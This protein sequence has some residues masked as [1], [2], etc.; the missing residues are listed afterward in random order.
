MKYLKL[1]ED[2]AQDKY[3]LTNK[4]PDGSLSSSFMNVHRTNGIA[5][6]GSVQLRALVEELE[7]VGWKYTFLNSRESREKSIEIADN[8]TDTIL[9]LNI[10]SMK[11]HYLEM[12]DSGIVNP[13]NVVKF[14]DFFKE[15]PA[16]H[17]YHA[18]RKFKL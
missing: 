4:L 15:N 9:W 1:F 14:E 16:F 17:G 8:L 7:K 18:G 5:F 6:T 11:C 3:I 13:D 10:D 2:Y 12:K